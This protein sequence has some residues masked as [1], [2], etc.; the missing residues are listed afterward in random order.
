MNDTVILAGIGLIL[1][2]L[3]SSVIW[4]ALYVIN[5]AERQLTR[6]RNLIVK[7][8]ADESAEADKILSSA[9]SKSMNAHGL[10]TALLPKIDKMHKLLTANMHILD[11][12]FVKY[13]ELQIVRFRASYEVQEQPAAPAAGYPAETAP[14]QTEVTSRQPEA[15]PE[16]FAI[17]EMRAMPQPSVHPENIYR[18]PEM[19]QVQPEDETIRVQRQ[20]QVR[21]P[22]PMQT[23]PQRPRMPAAVPPAPATARMQQPFRQPASQLDT[24]S[25]S[26]DHS[27]K[28]MQWDRNQLASASAPPEAIV[29]EGAEVPRKTP[30]PQRPAQGPAAPPAPGASKNPIISGEDIENTMDSFFGLGNQ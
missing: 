20:P 9:L 6:E 19:P 22:N 16:E 15:A 13:M 29:V 5:K 28:T 21:R 7:T 4:I 3:L 23:A 30:P 17:P 8:I 11:I 12:Y 24:R 27:E 10:R 1:G 18:P 2:L 26:V 25:M 14:R